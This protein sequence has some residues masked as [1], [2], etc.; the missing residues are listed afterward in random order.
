MLMTLFRSA[1]INLLLVSSVLAA[2]ARPLASSAATKSSISATAPATPMVIKYHFTERGD[3]HHEYNV[4]LIR[5]V[6]EITRSEFGEFQIQ[7]YSQAP[8][9]RRQAVL[10]NEGELMNV[11][12]APPG[13]DIAK[14]EVIEVP[15]DILRGLQGYRVLMYNRQAQ[16]DF[17]QVKDLE[18]LKKLRIGQGLG[19]AELPIYHANGIRPL[20]PPNLTGL[21]PMLG[22]KRIDCIPLGIN[23]VEKIIEREHK[24]FPFLEIEPNLLV[25]YD[26][27]I[28][29]YVSKKYPEI[30]RR[31]ELGLKKLKVSGDFD[32]LFQKYH[33]HEIRKL[34][35]QNRKII[36]LKSPFSRNPN[37]CE[38]TQAIPDFLNHRKNKTE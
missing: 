6:L 10:L 14:A 21:Y 25:Y 22:F 15:V 20:E 8:V 13:N 17:S 30:A 12:W 3:Y 4:E 35:L 32:H 28:Y 7:T 1:I 5:R 16:V 38:G 19:W 9:A 11:Q 34:K 37:Q 29:F 2:N 23:E 27:P 18:S 26:F 33:L 36:C 24:E 31:F